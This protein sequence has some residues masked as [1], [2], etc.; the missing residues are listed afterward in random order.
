MAKGIYR[1]T[2]EFEESLSAYTGA[3]YVIA[4]DNASNALFLSLYYE[5]NIAKT[6]KTNTITIPERTYISVPCEILNAGLKVKFKPVEGKTIK[7]AYQL[8][9]SNV[10]DSALRF[11]TQMYIPGSFMCI[12]M[13]GALKTAKALS[14][15]GA[16]LCDSKEAYE[17][18]KKSRFSGRNEISY[19]D[20]S[21]TQTGW[22]FYLNP[23]LSLRCLIMM[24]Q[25][26]DNNG[27]KSNPDVELPYPK[28]SDFSCYNVPQQNFSRD[29]VIQLIENFTMSTYKI[30]LNSPER[31]EVCDKW[32]KENLT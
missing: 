9:G 23:E 22:N 7:G 2:E 16:I 26:Y 13:T 20:D 28:L 12:S 30:P 17:W 29:E 3:P 10:W 31:G 1:I 8:E 18:F 4:L 5:K 15:V 24:S 32:F 14:K 25:F 21:F 6:L 27:A 11:T 19:H